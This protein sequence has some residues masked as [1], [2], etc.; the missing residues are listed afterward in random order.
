MASPARSKQNR[1]RNQNVV[2]ASRE[3]AEDFS[4]WPPFIWTSAEMG[5]L[6]SVVPGQLTECSE[7]CLLAVAGSSGGHH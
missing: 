4:P 3:K 1:L 7:A 6:H 5:N 2:Q